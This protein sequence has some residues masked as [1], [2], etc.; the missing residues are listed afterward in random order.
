M[1]ERVRLYF[2]NARILK[3]VNEYGEL[4]GMMSHKLRGEVASTAQRFWIE[5][6]WYL[7]D[8]HVDLLRDVAQ[9]LN[10]MVFAPKELVDLPMTLFFVRRGLAAKQ[11]KP[12]I[13][14]SLGG[15]DFIV[16]R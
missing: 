10:A 1:S 5:K 16:A 6:V 9:F 12:M 4:Q 8:A 14:G 13:K 3:R 7:K 15:A 2:Q 11:G